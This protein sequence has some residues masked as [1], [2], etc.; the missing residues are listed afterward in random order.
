VS[1][2]S[3]SSPQAPMDMPP[4]FA[5]Y[6]PRYQYFA[7]DFN[8]P[9]RTVRHVPLVPSERVRGKNYGVLPFGPR[10]KVI[11]YES[12]HGRKKRARICRSRLHGPPDRAT[13]TCTGFQAD[14]TGTGRAILRNN[15][16][17]YG[18]K[19]N[20]DGRMTRTERIA[21]GSDMRPAVSNL[22]TLPDLRRFSQEPQKAT[23]ADPL[24]LIRPLTSSTAPSRTRSGS[25]RN[26]KTS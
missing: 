9:L 8:C 24:E 13:V 21:S 3:T 15:H 26:T 1:E 12:N 11:R 6:A 19:G 17:Q 18:R 14:R 20:E 10:R 4:N 25:A 16:G 23:V 2:G 7:S 5:S 22:W